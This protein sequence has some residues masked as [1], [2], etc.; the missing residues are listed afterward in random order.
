MKRPFL[1]VLIRMN[2]NI[3]QSPN[4]MRKTKINS[5]QFGTMPTITPRGYSKSF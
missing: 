5:H 4:D 2:K 3:Y 1:E